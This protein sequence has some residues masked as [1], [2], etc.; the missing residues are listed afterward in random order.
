[1][2]NS[3]WRFQ[4]C[5][6]ALESAAAASDLFCQSDSLEYS[7]CVNRSAHS[8]RLQFVAMF[9][10]IDSMPQVPVIAG[11]ARFESR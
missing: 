5:G 1:M 6:D 7:P 10:S 2:V 8:L 3:V 11:T 4:R 9:V